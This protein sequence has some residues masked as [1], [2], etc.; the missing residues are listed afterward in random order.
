MYGNFNMGAGFVYFVPEH[1]V[2]I[3]REI[4][5][6]RHKLKADGVGYVEKGPKR[7][8]IRP[9]NIEFQGSSLA[10]R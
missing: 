6:S 4:A 8:V 10:V 7:I 9:K 2:P 1:Q 5:L 3:I